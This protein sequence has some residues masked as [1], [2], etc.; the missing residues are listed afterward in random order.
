[1]EAGKLDRRLTLLQLVRTTNAMNEVEESWTSAGTVWASKR[2]VSDKE[3]ADNQ[4][5]GATITTRFQVRHSELSDNV[6]PTWRVGCE[7]RTYEVRAVKE[8]GRRV[9]WEISAEAR[10]E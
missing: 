3:R 8:L 2:D 10:A 9:G 5:V 6:R 4:E 1:M 7:G